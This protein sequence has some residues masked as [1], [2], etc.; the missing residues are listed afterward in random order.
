MSTNG[1]VQN[2]WGVMASE[3]VQ[4]AAL[5]CITIMVCVGIVTIYFMNSE[6][7]D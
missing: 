6:E 7:N 5:V 4:I 2:V 3:T 1:S